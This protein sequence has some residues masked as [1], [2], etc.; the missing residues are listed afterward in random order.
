MMGNLVLYSLAPPTPY[1]NTHNIFYFAAQLYRA[2]YIMS[3]DAPTTWP[4]DVLETDPRARDFRQDFF[5]GNSQGR[6]INKG[7]RVSN[8]TTK[9]YASARLMTKLFFKLQKIEAHIKIIFQDVG[10]AMDLHRNL[11][12]N[13]EKVRTESFDLKDNTAKEKNT[14]REVVCKRCNTR[15]H[16][17]KKCRRA[18][19]SCGKWHTRESMPLPTC[20]RGN[21]PYAGAIGTGQPVRDWKEA[22]DLTMTGGDPSGSS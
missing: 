18:S 16:H 10:R 22:F 20:V 14:G 17:W 21:L 11:V 12:Q 1:H 6:T 5:E 2:P 19:C 15:G 9:R 8:T 4:W 7:T 3:D 13:I